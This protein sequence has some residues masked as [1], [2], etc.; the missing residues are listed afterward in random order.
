[1]VSFIC[2]LAPPGLVIIAAALTMGM[3]FGLTLYAWTTKE[4]FTMCGGF[5]FVCAMV[6]VIAGLLL[7]FTNSNA[8]HILYD[9]LGV[10]L[11]SIYIIYDT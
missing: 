1:M 11:F 10:A 4:D 3:F 5:L 2:G 8:A 7:M 9:V 6:M